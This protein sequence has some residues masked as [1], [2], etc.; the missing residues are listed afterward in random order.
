MN[1]VSHKKQ[2][3]WRQ[4][5]SLIELK[6]SLFR[7][8]IHMLSNKSHKFNYVILIAAILP[9]LKISFDLNHVSHKKQYIWR[10]I[11]SLIEFKKG[12]G[13]SYFD[14]KSHK[15]MFTLRLAFIFSQ[16]LIANFYIKNVFFLKII[17]KTFKFEILKKSIGFLKNR[18]F[19]TY[20]V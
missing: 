3:I 1:H 15:N 10:Q 13:G 20:R 2:Y 16:V 4:I 6:Q 7:V 18:A 12:S 14:N 8:R 19:G 5:I 17:N 9:K 11:I